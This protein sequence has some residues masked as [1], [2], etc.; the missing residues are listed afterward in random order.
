MTT[1][2]DSA[3]PGPTNRL[4]REKSPYL[5]QHANN[6]VDWFPWGDE[7]FATALEQ[8]RP[9]FL[10][11]GYATCHWCHV[12]EHES[13]EDP[14]VADLLNR[15]FVNIKVDREERPDIDQI[16][17]TVCQLLT[18]GGGWPLTII[19]T[20]DRKPFF[21]ATYIPKHSRYGRVGMMDL[22]PRVATAWQEQ[23]DELLASSDKIVGHLRSTASSGAAGTLQTGTVGRAVQQL[24]SRFDDLHGGFGDAPKFPSPH[25][26][27]LLVEHWRRT[28]TERSLAM[29]EQT[30][31]AMRRGG[32]YDHVGFGF[33][34]YSTDREWLVPHFEKMLYD[35]AMLTL[36]Y[37]EAYAVTEKPEHQRV[38]REVLTY[39]QRDMTSPEGAFYSAED[40]DSEGVEGKFYVWSLA[41]V[42]RILGDRDA[43]LAAQ[44]WNLT[45]DGNFEDESTRRKTGDNIPHRT[46]SLR[47]LAGDQK[48]GAFG[49][50]LERIRQQL[51]EVREDRI[52]PLK[53][54]KVLADWNGLMAAAMARAGVVLG[55]PGYVSAA[56]AAV[57]FVLE[58][59]RGTDGRLFHRFRDGEVAIPAFLDDYAFLTWAL[60]ELYDATLDPTH[61]DH[62]LQL[63]EDALALFWDAENGGFFFAAAGAD[64]LLVRQK[65]VYD[66]AVPSGNSVAMANL[67][68]LSR[69]TGRTDLARRA[70]QVAAAFARDVAR[71]PAAHTH[72]LSA[73]QLAAGASLEVVVAGTPG[74]EDTDRL[75]ATVR[76]AAVPGAALLLVPEGETGAPIRRLAPFAAGYVP[77]NGKAAAY[78]CRDF[79]CQ[80]PTT[81]PKELV[82]LMR[83]DPAKEE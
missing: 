50:R 12:M 15:T 1:A 29:V 78:V 9:V 56:A 75:I 30:L 80:L 64:D 11:I 14:E 2:S 81:D 18:G 48:T 19:M 27:L 31:E 54:D 65:E 46:R 47:E 44:V 17:M 10:S 36:A 32:I 20:P 79:T 60:V 43:A 70:D 23:R 34:R 49:Q 77:V 55:E 62:A 8:D 40:A 37:T 7:A 16:Y 76:D 39:V 41:E 28:G 71:G 3:E 51:F 67:V 4:A 68:R 74:A 66:G 26:L 6:P 24:A 61:L 69:L 38:V 45:A 21:A 73:V 58:H 83:E 22:I 13:F 82:R 52:H 72:L 35:Q 42:Q 5:L 57:R 33:H 25:N 53:D 63:Q 59:M